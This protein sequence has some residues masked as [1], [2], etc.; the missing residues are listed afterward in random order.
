MSKNIVEPNRTGR[1]PAVARPCHGAAA[2]RFADL[3]AQ[4][5]ALSAAARVDLGA[6]Y[7]HQP[8]AAWVLDIMSDPTLLR[9]AY[10]TMSSATFMK[11]DD[12]R[13]DLLRSVCRTLE[14]DEADAE[15]GF[16]TFSGGLAI[17]RAIAATVRSGDQVLTTNPSIDITT[18]M[19]LEQGDVELVHVGSPGRLLAID[20][21]AIVGA[22]TSRTRVVV[23]TSPENPTGAVLK[24]GELQLLATVC[25]ARRVTL[26][27]DHCFAKVN[28]FDTDIP[29]LGQLDIAKSDLQWAMIWDTGK[30]FGL[31][32]DK[33]GFVLCSANLHHA[34]QTSFNRLQFD[35]SR[36]L[37][38]CFTEILN[39]A[40]AERYY[41]DLGRLVRTNLEAL[42]AAV[43]DHRLPVRLLRPEAGSTVLMDISAVGSNDVLFSSEL[44]A[45]KRIGVISAG[46]FF[47]PMPNG[48]LPHNH[49]QYVRIALARAPA[50]MRLAARG[51]TEFLTEGPSH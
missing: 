4:E 1:T 20:V 33:L 24:R 36:R 10:A 7:P 27:V 15:H 13:R 22:M 14:M 38:L 45:S 16:V 48:E 9:R 49:D 19:I 18:A 40:S 3:T 6:G 28:P 2:I 51:I 50:A 43:A 21:D 41:A 34:M 35:V 17:H 5:K 32:E 42:E 31:N 29:I 12:V 47:F 44:L 46:S 26:I 23:L 11:Y 30:T 37:Q 25:A 8:I 39:K